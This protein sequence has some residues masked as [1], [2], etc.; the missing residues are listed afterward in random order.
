MGGSRAILNRK[1]ETIKKLKYLMN[2]GFQKK[3]L[4]R[5]VGVFSELYQNVILMFGIFLTLE[6]P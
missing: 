1:L 2:I 5:G 4:S 3:K 6:H